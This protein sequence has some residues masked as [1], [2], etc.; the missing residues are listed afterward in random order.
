MKPHALLLAAILCLASCQTKPSSTSAASEPRSLPSGNTQLSGPILSYANVVDRVA[1]AVVTVRSSRR[2]R[3]SQQFP[4]SDEP[5]FRRFFGGGFPSTPQIQQ[6]LGSGVIVRA[7]GHILT[8]HHVIDG[9]EEIKVDLSSHR[10]YSAKVIGSDA[11]SDLAVLK[12]SASDLPVLQLANS[13]QVRVGDISL[14]I[15]NPLGIG[16]TVTAGII[17]A[18]GRATGTGDGSFQDFLQTDAPIN[19]G[20]SGGALVNTRGELIGINSQILSPNG[21]NIGIGFAIPSNMA[22]TV[23]NQ[24]IG[25]GKVQRGMLGVGIQQVTSDLANGLGLKEARGVV[26]SSVTSG[27]PADKAGLKSGDVILKLN[28]KD[29][30]DSNELRNDIAA[31]SPGTETTLTIWREGKQQ[32]IRVRLGELTPETARASR[33]GG[34][35]Q[36]GSRLGITVTPLTPDL[37][38]QLGLRRGAQGLVIQDIDP[39]GPAAQAGLQ[40]GDVIE[41]VNRQPVRSPDDMRRALQ[42]SNGRPALLLVNR[43]GQTIFVPVPAP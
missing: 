41:Q 31:M 38:Q 17:S 43:G 26:I 42:S 2:V 12:I 18:K 9:A 22:N 33:Q 25:K 6:A 14:A 39:S 36:N 37:A 1:P 20:N 13:D 4:F 15:G 24:L 7:D 8:N 10:T 29:M 21:G 3:Q 5:F 32:D 11:P 30:N 23:M 28:G 34:G 35:E 16:E 27:G 19:Q 40:M